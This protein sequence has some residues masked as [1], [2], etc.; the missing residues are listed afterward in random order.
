MLCPACH[1]ANPPGIQFCT[2]CHSTLFFRCP[3]C[4]HEQP[5]NRICEKCGMDMDNFWR[6]QAATA[7]V[8]EI[9]EE[10]ERNERIENLG[11]SMRSQNL[12]AP[13]I[14]PLAASALVPA[15]LGWITGLLLK[16]LLDRWRRFAG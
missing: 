16:R 6:A 11:D 5:T 7:Q 3:H 12:A 15:P 14:V 8:I 1:T 4:W 10:A 9:K 13:D 2:H